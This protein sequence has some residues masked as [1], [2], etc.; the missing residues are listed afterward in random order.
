VRIKLDLLF[1]V[2]FSKKNISPRK[3][4]KETPVMRDGQGSGMIPSLTPP[5]SPPPH[6]CVQINKRVE[7]NNVVHGSEQ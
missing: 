4:R 6:S 1:F 2:K 7:M 5:L 3:K